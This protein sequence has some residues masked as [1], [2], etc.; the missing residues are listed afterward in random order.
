M[1]KKEKEDERIERIIR[2][3]LKLPENRR[4]INCNSLG[5]QY[6]CTTFLTF[7]CTNCSGIHREFTHRVKSVSMAKFK[8]EEVSALQAGGNERAR[9][10]YFKEWDP[11]RNSYPDGSNL[12]RLRDF[13]KHV[14]VDRKYS[15][16]RRHERLPKLRLTS[17]FGFLES[18]LHALYLKLFSFIKGS[19]AL[20]Q[21]DK[22]E[23]RESRKLGLNCGHYKSPNYESRYDQKGR[24]HP[25]GISDDKSIKYYYD[26]RRSPRYAQENSRYGGFK[27][28]PVRFAVVDD[29]FRDDGAQSGRESANHRFSNK[30]GRFGSLSPDRKKSMDQ[31]SSPVAQPVKDIPGQNAPAMQV[32]ECSKATVRKDA[33]GSTHNQI[34]GSK[35]FIDG[36]TLEE[37]NQ[38]LESLINF[39]SDCMP[40]NAATGPQ[41]QENHQLSDGGNHK[42]NGPSTMQNASQV[43]KPNTLE[44]LLF[45]LSVPSVE[46]AG[47]VSEDSNKD[48]P[49]STTSGGNMPMSGDISAAVP[50][51]LMLTLLDNMG[52]STNATGGNVPIDVSPAVTPGQMLALSSSAGTSTIASGENMPNGNVSAA[53]PW[54]QISTSPNSAGLSISASGKSTPAGG[55]SPAATVDQT[56]SLHDT[57]DSTTPSTTSLPVQPSD[58]APSQA[59]PAIHGDSTFKAPNGKQVPSMQQHQLSEFPSADSKPSGQPTCTTTVGPPNN[60]L[61]TSLNVPNAQGPDSASAEFTHDVTKVAQE[62]S[63]GVKSQ[64]LPVETKS[65]GRKELFTASYSPATGS[66]PGWQSALPYGMGFGMQYYPNAAPVVKYLNHAKSSNPFDLNDETTSVQV[67][68][69]AL[70]NVSVPRNLLPSTSIDK[71]SL[72]LMATQ[73]PSYA[74]AMP[75]QSSSFASPTSGAYMGQQLH[76]NTQPSRPQGAA[77]AY[78]TDAHF[79]SQNITQQSSSGYPLPSAPNSLPSMGGNPFG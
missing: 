39:D 2:G 65:I 74:S 24:S 38:N 12:H 28:S 55:I 68:P 6:V 73:A 20:I 23:S 61:W 64:Q 34:S 69:A 4:C 59:A 51:G 3:L 9:Q 26:E 50:S 78:D 48:N 72:G 29:R 21:S 25:G 43:P 58:G 77:G 49:P 60:Q 31:S 75:L 30:D 7:I 71:N 36:K 37:K 27:K 79:G 22:E 17:L 18:L 33:D 54:G 52:A 14:Y 8:A 45:E 35:G 1:S 63:S 44:F 66:I 62:S 53:V 46:T 11:Q 15:G 57:F 16:E 5:P 32:G 13:I 40:S 76:M 41:T 19:C 56:L 67:S 10:L 47:S 42:S 70:T